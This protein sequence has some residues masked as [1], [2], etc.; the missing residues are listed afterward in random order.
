MKYIIVIISSLLL[1]RCSESHFTG[2]YVIEDLT[3]SSDTLWILP[4]GVFSRK[5]YDQYGVLRLD[6][7]GS[8]EKSGLDIDMNKFFL[9]IDRDLSLYPELVNDTNSS[10]I[11]PLTRTQGKPSLCPGYNGVFNKLCFIKID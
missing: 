7:E 8:W 2:T 5:V 4:D 3:L 9:N 1:I 11:M 6:I 10:V